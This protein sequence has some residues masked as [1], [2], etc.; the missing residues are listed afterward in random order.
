MFSLLA[1]PRAFAFSI[2][3]LFLTTCSYA[4]DESIFASSVTYCNPP[5]SLLIQRFEI[6][7]FPQ[8]SSVAFNVSISSVQA[9]VNV[10]ANIFLNVYGMNPVNVTLDLCSIL[11]G[12][13]CPLPMYNFTGS[14][15]LTLPA[16]LGVVNS[17]PSIAYKI[18]DL[19][20][21]A[22]LTLREVNTGVVKACVQATLSNGWSAHQTAVEWSTGGVALAGL[23]SAVWHS[24]ASPEAMAPFRLLELMYLYQMIASSAFLNLNYPS[25]YRAFA[26]NF[27][28]AVGLIS[29]STSSSLQ[30]SIN[31]MRHLTG[32]R[33]A[34]ATGGSAVGL[35]N[36]KLSPYNQPTKNIVVGPS[37][38]TIF[39]R[40]LPS[41][42]LTAGLSKLFF[43][44]TSRSLGQDIRETVKGEVQTVTAASSNVLQAGVPI[45]VNTIHIATANAFMTVFLCVL[46]MFAIAIG[47][48]ILGYGVMIVLEH[49]R[50]QRHNSMPVNFDYSSWV[51]SWFLRLSLVATFPLLI[52]I[53]YQWTLKDSWLSIFISVLTL[54]AIMALVGYPA[55]QTLRLSGRETP[56][57]LYAPHKPQI[58]QNGPLYAQY[59]S[60]RYYFFLP[61]LAAFFLR[62]ILIAF[63]KTSSE[64]QLALMIVIESGLVA[65]HI[66]L[67]PFKTK[68]GQVFSTYLA[69]TRL[70]CTGLMIAFLEKLSVKAIPRV[71]IGIIIA[72][73]FSI[74]VVVVV[75][76][77][78]L[79][80]GL[81]RLWSR[82][83]AGHGSSS[84]SLESPLGSEGSM[85]EKG[86]KS[87]TKS[88]IE[89]P[90]SRRVGDSGVSLP[91]PDDGYV[92][93]IGR[94]RP[95]NPTPDQ[96]IHLDPYMNTPYPI[97][98][99]GTTVTTM[100]PPSM[101][102]RDSGTITVG[103]LLPRRW[104][105][106][107]SQP[108]SPVGSSLGHQQEQRH[109]GS[110][111]P[112]PMPSA[113]ASP[114]ENGYL[115]RNASLRAHQQMHQHQ[116]HDIQEEK[117]SSS[118]SLAPSSSSRT[119]VETSATPS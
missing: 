28:W 78:I 58:N 57:A 117:S 29:S 4:R 85:L 26:L 56:V 48:F 15:S 9:N 101:Y 63:V 93:E 66:V 83:K 96:N 91:Y 71:V 42:E 10:S 68:G 14:D 67:K 76:N 90:R 37:I 59:R 5:E 39:S 65:A 92:E 20:G 62:A 54:L 32:G 115:S 98:P 84:P 102:S 1:W 22:Q 52:F 43:S 30:N 112:S 13:L 116:H 82:N 113:S 41:A 33:L 35:V 49:R 17:I 19:E 104:S 23:V 105:F 81:E 97:S 100:D 72:L 111:T 86:M 103:S 27:G 11:G 53:F 95:V 99:T 38:G 24:I 61:L 94:E 40:E 18:P 114:S 50:Q 70:V 45:Y 47:I 25:V 79:H 44:E 119:A 110:L 34:D 88:E 108:S 2:I 75:I 60:T 109:R 12:A 89:V 7:Y 51:K 16:S 73:A 3:L 36:R 80:T 8:N 46:I 77:M 106:S 31:H 107:F 55:F 118:T 87:S 74:S 64:A 6:A 69:I 21:F